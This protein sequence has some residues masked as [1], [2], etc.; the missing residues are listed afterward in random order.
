MTRRKIEVG[1]RIRFR[2][3]TRHSNE[4]VW[5]KVVGVNPVRVRFHGWAE[6]QVRPREISGVQKGGH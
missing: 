3:V 5:R 6:F 4:Q 1:D 2:A